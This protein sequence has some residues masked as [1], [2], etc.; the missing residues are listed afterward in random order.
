MKAIVQNGYGSPDVLEIKEIEEPVVKDD[1]VL[2]RVHAAALH[3]GD[4]F[5]MR[6]V[7]I[8]VRMMIGLRKPRKNYVLGIDVAAS[9]RGAPGT[10]VPQRTDRQHRAGKLTRV[11]NVTAGRVFP[12]TAGRL[13]LC[14][15][16]AGGTRYAQPS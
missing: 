4:Y 11:A 9:R 8:P 7:P 3:A 14:T 10:D 16:P 1:G 6:G 13:T 5:G 15:T 2:V 12:A